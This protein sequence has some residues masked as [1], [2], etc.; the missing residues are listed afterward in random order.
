VFTKRVLQKYDVS[1]FRCRRCG[2]L[3]SENAYWLAEAY[4]SSLTALDVGAVYRCQTQA[5]LTQD[6][7]VND[8]DVAGRFLDYGGG[9]GLFTRL[10]RDFGLD[11]YRHDRYAPNLFAQCFDLC[12]LPLEN[13]HFELIT[14]FEVMEHL[15][16][17]MTALCEMLGMSDLIF[18]STGLAPADGS[19]EDWEYLSPVHGQHISFFNETSLRRAADLLDCE[20]MSDGASQHLMGRRDL[21]GLSWDRTIGRKLRDRVKRLSARLRGAP[22]RPRVRSLTL[23]DARQAERRLIERGPA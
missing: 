15:E 21:K 6:L 22:V 20:L 14:C 19:P 5:R 11:F 1:Y 18:F 12:D 13:R 23:D 7:I 16:D 17:P 9:A 3:Q 2:F 8:L 4:T 10:M